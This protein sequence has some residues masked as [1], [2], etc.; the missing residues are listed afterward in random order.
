M[1]I[2]DLRSNRKAE[3]LSDDELA[4]IG[5]QAKSNGHLHANG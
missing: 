4:A 3:D 5:L 1:E 2:E